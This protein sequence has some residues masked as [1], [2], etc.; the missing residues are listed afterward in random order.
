MYNVQLNHIP[1]FDVNESTEGE[2]IEQKIE[3][4]L[5]IGEPI[6]DG[7]PEIYTGREEGVP[8][9]YNI[10]SDRFDMALEMSDKIAQDKLQKRAE[11]LNKKKEEVN[12]PPKE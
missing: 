4:A 2:T 8:A 11:I 7:A 6:T 1:V 9:E 10:R 3:R 5:E 12:P